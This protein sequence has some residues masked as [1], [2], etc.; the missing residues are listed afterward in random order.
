MVNKKDKRFL[1]CAI[2]ISTIILNGCSMFGL[3]RQR[4]QDSSVTPPET[5]IIPENDSGQNDDLNNNIY[6]IG[7]HVI[8]EN[9]SLL[10]NGAKDITGYIVTVLKA[11]CYSKYSDAEIPTE[12]YIECESFDFFNAG[13]VKIEDADNYSLIL[14]DVCIEN[15]NDLEDFNITNLNLVT[16]D[17]QGV[18]ANISYPCYFSAGFDEEKAYHCEILQGDSINAQV[19]WL[20][21]LAHYD[22][23]SLWLQVNGIPLHYVDIRNIEIK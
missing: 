22:L 2:V 18:V 11:E 17:D 4:L 14:C 10:N 19:G 5:L 9:G 8:I 23:T 7:D 3:N 6:H 21:D 20:V 13:L 1:I 12:D 16:V 15:V